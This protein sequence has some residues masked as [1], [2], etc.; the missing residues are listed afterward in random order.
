[1]AQEAFDGL[2]VGAVGLGVSA[3]QEGHQ[4]GPGFPQAGAQLAQDAVGQERSLVQESFEVGAGDLH[5]GGGL[6]GAHRGRARALVQQPHFPEELPVAVHAHH[7]LIPVGEALADLDLAP[8]DDEETLRG[9]ALLHDQ[10]SGAV[11]A[12]LGE[13]G[14]LGQ[15]EVGKIGEKADFKMRCPQRHAALLGYRD[16]WPGPAMAASPLN[17]SPQGLSWVGNEQS[18]DRGPRRRL[19]LRGGPLPA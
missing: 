15:V 5:Q 10:L 17:N 9:G 13:A 7:E 14:D 4:Q 6:H 11:R 1:L 12:G 16:F 19:A 18:A 8:D 3:F 2:Q